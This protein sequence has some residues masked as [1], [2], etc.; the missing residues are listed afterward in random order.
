MSGAACLRDGL[1]L[2]GENLA[3]DPEEVFAFHPR[4]ARH[5]ANQERPVDPPETLRQVRRGDDLVQEGNA[6]SSS[7]IATPS[8]IGN[9]GGISIRC[10]TTGCSGP[11]IAPEAMRKSSE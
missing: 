1:P 8:S 6:Q 7:S 5:A 4:L 11:N 10:S 3:V 2:A 9:A